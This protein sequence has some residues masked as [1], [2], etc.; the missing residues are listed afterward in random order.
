MRE[1]SASVVIDCEPAQA[2]DWVADHRHVPDVLDGVTHW[3]PLGRATGKGA[4]YEVDMRTFGFPLSAELE[5]NVWQRPSRLGW[6]SISGLI[7]Q[8]GNWRFKPVA[9]GTEVSLTIAY[10]PPAAAIGNFLAGRVEGMVRA[11]LEAALDRMRDRIERPS[12]S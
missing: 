9:G 7:E 2:F 10:E 6:R 3:Q 1:F 4:R 12:V 11:R 5:L 8:T